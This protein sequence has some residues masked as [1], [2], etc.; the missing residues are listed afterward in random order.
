MA[1]TF[2]DSGA[3]SSPESLRQLPP[4]RRVGWRLRARGEALLGLPQHDPMAGLGED[5][6]HLAF[7][8]DR[9]RVLAQSR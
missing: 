7:G 5:E 9:S 2:R 3:A 8:A 4:H 6:D 1:R